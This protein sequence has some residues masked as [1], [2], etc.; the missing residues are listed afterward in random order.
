MALEDIKLTEDE[1]QELNLAAGLLGVQIELFSGLEAGNDE[2]NFDVKDDSPNKADATVLAD[3]LFNFIVECKKEVSVNKGTSFQRIYST[4]PPWDEN[5]VLHLDTPGERTKAVKIWKDKMVPFL[6]SLVTSL[7][8]MPPA[9]SSKK[10]I[11]LPDGVGPN[12]PWKTKKDI[13]GLNGKNLLRESLFDFINNIKRFLNAFGK[14]YFLRRRIAPPPGVTSVGE[15]I[16]TDIVLQQALGLV[17]GDT[18]TPVE[19]TH[20]I[21]FLEPA[22]YYLYGWLRMNILRL[23]PRDGMI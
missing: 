4:D 19:A 6:E 21:A 15:N 9:V 7:D 8:G 22:K 20:Y 5:F 10:T 2:G 23:W 1:V 11:F 17:G 13:P 16:P 18:A 3:I 14:T 12:S